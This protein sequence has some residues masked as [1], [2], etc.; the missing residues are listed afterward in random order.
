MK[1]SPKERPEAMAGKPEAN[2]TGNKQTGTGRGRSITARWKE[3]YGTYRR[4]KKQGRACL[5]DAVVERPIVRPS[6]VTDSD[7]ATQR[8]ACNAIRGSIPMLNSTQLWLPFLNYSFA[9]IKEPIP[10][11]IAGFNPKP[12]R[13]SRC[14]TGKLNWPSARKTMDGRGS[15]SRSRST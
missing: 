13:D 4:R 3:G 2:V 6:V 10:L 9:R 5:V 11:S 15:D 7:G 1:G 8:C 14:G 12:G